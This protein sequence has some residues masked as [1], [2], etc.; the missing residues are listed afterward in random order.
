MYKWTWWSLLDMLT[1]YIPYS[2]K[3]SPEKNFL[4]FRP[5]ALWAKLFSAN[6]FTQWKFITLKF[7]HAQVFTCGCQAVLVVSHDHQSAVLPGIQT[8]SF[9]ICSLAWCRYCCTM[10]HFGFCPILPDPYR[11]SYLLLPSQRPTLPWTA[12][13][14]L[15]PRKLRSE[16]CTSSTRIV[17]TVGTCKYGINTFDIWAWHVHSRTPPTTSCWAT[18]PV[19]ETKF[20]KIFLPIQ[21]MHIKWNFYPAKFFAIRYMW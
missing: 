12:C 10:L 3:F 17:R 15:R 7:L 18:R 13:S 6:Y 9:L 8:S 16:W 11:R 2:R 19:G 1:V 21:S 4:L 5:G 20:G 14:K